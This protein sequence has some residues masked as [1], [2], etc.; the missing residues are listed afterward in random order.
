[1]NKP[2]S[3]HGFNRIYTDGSKTGTAVA[4]AASGPTLLYIDYQITFHFFKLKPV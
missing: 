1:M 2:F 3:F 4:A